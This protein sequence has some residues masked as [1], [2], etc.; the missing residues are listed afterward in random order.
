MWRYWF[1]E[2]PAVPLFFV[3]LTLLCHYFSSHLPCWALIFLLT[4]PAVPSFYFH[5][6]CCALIFL[7]TYPAVPSF[8]SHLPC[9]ALI[10][11]SPTLFPASPHR[12]SSIFLISAKPPGPLDTLES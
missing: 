4:Y 12:H 3:A 7:R 2:Y 8:Y 11:L 1:V 5:L 9:C 10:F 6:P